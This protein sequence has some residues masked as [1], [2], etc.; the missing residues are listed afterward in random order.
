MESEKKLLALAVVGLLLSGCSPAFMQGFANGLQGMPASAPAY[1]YRPLP[2][3]TITNC[4]TQGGYGGTSY[5]N[6][7][8]Y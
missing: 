7:T 5:T 2:R 6:C 8:S 3:S 4:T 1:Q